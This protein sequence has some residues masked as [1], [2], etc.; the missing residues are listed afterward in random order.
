M[1]V[2]TR[3]ELRDSI[4]EKKSEANKLLDKRG[5]KE[6]DFSESDKERL[7]ELI[8]LAQEDKSQLELLD[9][10]ADAFEVG[11]D[12]DPTLRDSLKKH[13]VK[14]VPAGDGDP[15]SLFD[16]VRFR[17][18]VQPMNYARVEM[19]DSEDPQSIQHSK[20][21]ARAWGEALRNLGGVK[22]SLAQ[23]IEDSLKTQIRQACDTEAG[24]PF[25]SEGP[26]LSSWCE[27]GFLTNPVQWVSGILRCCD[28]R[29][30]MRQLARV[31]TVD[32][33]AKLGVRRR[34]TKTNSAQWGNTC[35]APTCDYPTGEAIYL[36]PHVITGCT[37][38]CRELTRRSVED[39]G[40]WYADELA[41]NF[42]EVMEEGYL[43]GSGSGQ[44][45]GL[46][47]EGALVPDRYIPMSSNGL[48]SEELINLLI[49]M[50]CKIND[51]FSAGNLGW[52][53]SK[54]FLCCLMKMHSETGFWLNLTADKGL[55]G[56]FS[57]TLLGNP[58]MTSEFIKPDAH[59]SAGNIPL[60]HGD[61][62]QYWIVDRNAMLSERDLCVANDRVAQYTRMWTG[63]SPMCDEGFAAGIVE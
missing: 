51:C 50:T 37:S 44:S 19:P 27:S 55:S 20:M 38:W 39:V 8:K 31:I 47:A 32:S 29:V 10:M 13:S 48:T 41:Q 61:F 2:K 53:M 40:G 58:I 28:R 60:V 33:A 42:Q 35:E 18:G 7:D 43:Y 16:E 54:E 3:K 17:S 11:D 15:P 62:S 63:G 45:L 14:F 56:A 25:P 22:G 6:S 46:L 57:R 1:T 4:I 5:R 23:A 34:L 9:K 36:E 49:D 59:N 30:Q 52:L 12:V 26:D 24:C 21:Y